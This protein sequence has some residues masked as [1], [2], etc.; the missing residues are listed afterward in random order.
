MTAFGG[1]SVDI[2]RRIAAIICASTA[3][4]FS[5]LSPA[6]ADDEAETF[7]AGIM[8]EAKPF[9]LNADEA[10]RN[11]GIGELV[12]K[13][14]DMRRAAHFSLGQY[15]RQL[16]EDQRE[17]YYTVF[18]EYVTPIYQNLL[19]DYAGRTLY[20]T[21]SQTLSARDIIVNCQ[22][23]NPAADDPL[24]DA[25][26]HWRLYRSRDG[27]LS[28]FDAGVT[29]PSLELWLAAS[30][31]QSQFKSIVANNGGGAAGIDALIAELQAEVAKFTN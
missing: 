14:V 5:A 18:A 21:G 26:V 1:V 17:T 2:G 20:V 7:I 27:S 16:R 8:L 24:K 4:L 31:F 11:K 25:V 23:E 29:T 6:F 28:L 13:Y 22:I 3:L 15:A 12:E 30:Q 19:S 10:A 9:L